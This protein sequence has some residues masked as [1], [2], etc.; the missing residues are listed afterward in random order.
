MNALALPSPPGGSAPSDDARLGVGGR[1]PMSRGFFAS[2]RSFKPLVTAIHVN[3]PLGMPDAVN[4]PMLCHNVALLLSRSADGTSCAW[5]GIS[6]FWSMR[7][8]G[9]RTRSLLEPT[10]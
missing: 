6:R 4:T 5:R 1:C 9:A 2:T 10:R 8:A 7:P 3:A